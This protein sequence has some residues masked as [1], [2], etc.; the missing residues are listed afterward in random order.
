[1]TRLTTMQRPTGIDRVATD[2][3]VRA[4][5]SPFFDMEERTEEI[6]REIARSDGRTC[7]CAECEESLITEESDQEVDKW[8]N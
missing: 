4:A 3:E 8:T 6:L 1:M 2:A 5:F 7:L